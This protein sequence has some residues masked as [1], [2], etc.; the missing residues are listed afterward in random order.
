MK[1]Q[2]R[3]SP[4]SLRTSPIFFS[5]K[6]VLAQQMRSCVSRCFFCFGERS[7]IASFH[8]IQSRCAEFRIALH[9]INLLSE[10]GN[11][12]SSA[13]SNR[14]PKRPPVILKDC[15]VSL[16]ILKR[17]YTSLRNYYRYANEGTLKYCH[18]LP[19]KKSG[20]NRKVRSRDRFQN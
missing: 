3:F 20:G 2:S 1:S 18:Y 19:I 6:C 17:L 10:I 7:C 8:K 12:Y 13:S 4:R 14:S 11:H 16:H 15:I 5:S 9:R